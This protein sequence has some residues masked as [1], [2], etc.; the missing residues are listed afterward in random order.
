MH[1]RANEMLR[2]L[3][4]VVTR[5]PRT[6]KYYGNPQI[7]DGRLEVQVGQV[8]TLWAAPVDV[9]RRARF[10]GGPWPQA[11]HHRGASHQTAHILCIANESADDFF[12]DVLLQFRSVTMY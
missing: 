9:G 10:R 7:L 8:R 2:V 6:L 12:I 11:S 4:D 5:G 1:L 3:G